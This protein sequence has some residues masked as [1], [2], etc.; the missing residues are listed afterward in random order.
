[1]ETQQTY[2]I[3]PPEAFAAA[4]SIRD[5]ISWMKSLN[6]DGTYNVGIEKEQAIYREILIKYAA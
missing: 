2:K 4:R 3:F 6:Q 1:M 5:Q